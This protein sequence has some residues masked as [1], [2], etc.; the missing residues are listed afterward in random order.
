MQHGSIAVGQRESLFCRLTL[1]LHC[2]NQT[3]LGILLLGFSKY[4]VMVS[5]YIGI[6][7]K[8]IHVVGVSVLIL[9]T[10]IIKTY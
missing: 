8:G 4:Q 2:I 10:E 9:D 7:N 3:I 5:L 6:K 1:L